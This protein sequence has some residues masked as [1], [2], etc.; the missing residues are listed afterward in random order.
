MRPLLVIA[1]LVLAGLGALAIRVVL[2]GRGALAEGDDWMARDRPAEAIRAYETSARWYLPLAPHVDEAYDR[3]RALATSEDLAVSLAAWRAIRSAARTTRG[4]WP[5]HAGDLAAADAA[6]AR[7]SA[8]H[9]SAGPAGDTVAAREAWYQTRLARDPRPSPGAAALAVLGIL[10]W[11]GG[12]VALVRRGI[13]AQGSVIRRP[14]LA[15]A[16]SIV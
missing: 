12:T 4:L 16:A 6:I 13:D 7:L 11:V 1:A 15:S 9:P 2:E 10:L 14:A 8:R 3:L 5:P